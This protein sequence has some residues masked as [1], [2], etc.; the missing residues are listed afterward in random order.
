MALAASTRQLGTTRM[1]ETC[2]GSGAALRCLYYPL[3]SVSYLLKL[4]G[5]LQCTPRARPPSTQALRSLQRPAWPWQQLHAL[6]CSM[7]H[8]QRA[9]RP[10][11]SAAPPACT[12]RRRPAAAARPSVA[13]L[14]SSS[15]T[16]RVSG[17]G[18]EGCGSTIRPT[19]NHMAAPCK[20]S[21]CWRCGGGEA[22]LSHA[23]V[24]PCLLPPPAA[25]LSFLNW[26]L[27]TAV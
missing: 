12:W 14:T 23:R 7:Q 13:C 4:P 17:H 25:P 9:L 19:V 27:L 16:G 2:P 1:G 21:C 5:A 15:P 3:A 22:R 24:A 8:S 20:A 26:L 6:R 10:G 11:G 18:Q